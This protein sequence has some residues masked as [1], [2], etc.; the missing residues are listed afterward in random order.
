MRT[1][2]LGINA[3]GKTGKEESDEGIEQIRVNWKRPLKLSSTL[4]T[5]IVRR[6]GLLL[7]AVSQS[8]LDGLILA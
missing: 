5:Y 6:T 7:V 1:T 3:F 8:G 4:V 2:N